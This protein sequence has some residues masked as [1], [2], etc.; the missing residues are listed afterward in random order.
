MSTL[1][2]API[3]PSLSNAIG[4]V[5]RCLWTIARVSD[6]LALIA[7]AANCAVPDG[8]RRDTAWSAVTC[9]TH[10]PDPVAKNTSTVGVRPQTLRAS[11][12]GCAGSQ[13]GLTFAGLSGPTVA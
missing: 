12:F 2:R 13:R 6:R 7:T 10:A 9:R 5:Q 4:I 8:K 11:G 1:Y 3:A